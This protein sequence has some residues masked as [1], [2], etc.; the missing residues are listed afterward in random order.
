MAVQIQLRRGTAAAWTAANPV[1]ASGELGI[2]TDTGKSKLGDGATTWSALPY[3]WVVGSHA[4]SHQHGGGDEVATATPGANAIPKAGAGGA[5]GTGWIPDLSGVYAIAA[6]GVTNGDAHDHSGGDGGQI[7]HGGLAGLADDDH[8]QYVK[9]S[10]ATAVNDFLVA[11]GVGAFVKKTLAEVKAILG[12]GSLAYKSTVATGDIDDDAVT[13]AKLQNVSATD[14][15]LGR[16]TAGAG[17]A[18]EIA[19]TAAGRALVDDADA[20]AQRTT[21]GLQGLDLLTYNNEQA[22]LP[23]SKMQ[24]FGYGIGLNITGLS[25]TAAVADLQTAPGSG[26][27]WGPRLAD[28]LAGETV[29]QKDVVYLKAADSRWWKA[30]ADVAATSGPVAIA[31]VVT[32]GN[33]GDTVL[34]LIMGV[35]EVTGWGLTLGSLYYVSPATAGLITA[36]APTSGQFVRAVGHPLATT[37]FFFHPS[38]DYGEAA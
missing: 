13:Y 32:G 22:T 21:L 15:L 29:A 20:A 16:V 14:K 27:T 36:T 2:E 6:K 7:D 28:G 33:A 19:C 26:S 5:L 34:L 37:A 9:H 10:L 12:L 11:S 35:L 24:G 38:V 1:L 23:D 18:E 3:A 8:P 25:I 17:D 4:A 31:L 30:K